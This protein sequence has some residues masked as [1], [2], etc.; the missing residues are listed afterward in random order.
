MIADSSLVG[1]NWPNVDRNL[2]SICGK[3]HEELLG[4]PHQRLDA[5]SRDDRAAHGLAQARLLREAAPQAGEL[6]PK[7]AD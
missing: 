4:L 6:L 1:D 7:K 3:A 5:E 2:W